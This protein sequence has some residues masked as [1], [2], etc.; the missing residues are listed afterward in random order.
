VLLASSSKL[1]GASNQLA[2]IAVGVAAVLMIVV[3]WGLSARRKASA[4]KS[5]V[6]AGAG[7]R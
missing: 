3:S 1:L 4:Q 5:L 7:A 6:D 2:A